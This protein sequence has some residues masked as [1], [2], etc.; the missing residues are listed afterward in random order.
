MEFYIV[1]LFMVKKLLNLINLSIYLSN[2][3]KENT[4]DFI[5]DDFPKQ[6]ITIEIDKNTNKSSNGKEY[7][8]NHKKE[9]IF[10]TK[11][12]ER[13]N[14]Y[15]DFLN[16]FNNNIN[17]PKENYMNELYNTGI[18]KYYHN[19]QRPKFLFNYLDNNPKIQNIKKKSQIKLIINNYEEIEPKEKTCSTPNGSKLN[20]FE[21]ANASTVNSA[22]IKLNPE[23]NILPKNKFNVIKDEN[24]FNCENNKKKDKKKRGRKSLKLGKKQHSAF[25]QDNIIR[26]IQVH[27]LSFIIDFTNDIIRAVFK[28]N[29]NI[30]FKSINYEFKKTVNHS[31]IQKLYAKTIGDIVQVA[32]SSKNK[33]FVKNINQIVYDKLCN[34]DIFKKLFS[35]SYLYMF[36]KYYYLNKREIDFF[37]YKVNLSQ[38]TKLFM[39]LLEK[40]KESAEYIKKIAEDFFS[41]KTK[42]SNQIFVIKKNEL[43]NN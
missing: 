2:M 33:K 27:F 22:Q 34:I 30:F 26:K 38:R 16:F 1:I 19:Y 24:G 3:K 17:L 9:K 4:E 43:Q 12:R 21:S 36:N 28:D 32:A 25:D 11:K 7:P 5:K 14:S 23:E 10:L 6:K 41:N 37:G 13:D 42:D 15:K 20:Y 8:K 31:Y 35:I 40:N 29:K 39:D 18:F